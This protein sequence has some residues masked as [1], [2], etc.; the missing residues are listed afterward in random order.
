MLFQNIMK[1]KEKKINK[2]DKINKIFQCGITAMKLE[3][4]RRRA[5]FSTAG[6]SQF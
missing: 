3:T 6:Q 5:L 4:G 1:K 2:N